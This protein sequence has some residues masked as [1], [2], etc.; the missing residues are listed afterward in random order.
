M[1][2]TFQK[3]PRVEAAP[4]NEEAILFDPTGSKFFMLNSTSSFIWERLTSPT[5]AES[6][7]AEICKSFDNVSP[8]DALKDVCSAL[9]QMLSMQI[10]IADSVA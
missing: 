1:N 3:N 8:T 10:V 2:R 6:L 7:A 9:D 5:T 4:L